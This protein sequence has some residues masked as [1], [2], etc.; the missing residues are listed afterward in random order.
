MDI[1]DNKSLRKI[2]G[3]DHKKDQSKPIVGIKNKGK[4][5]EESAKQAHLKFLK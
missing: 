5:K 4:I 2:K 3:T 1:R